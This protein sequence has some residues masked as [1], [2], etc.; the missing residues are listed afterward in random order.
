MAENYEYAN[1]LMVHAFPLLSSIFNLLFF[2]VV[3]LKRD[4]KAPFA[5][6]LI[7]IPVN[8]YGKYFYGHAVYWQSDLV[9]WSTPYVTNAVV[10]LMAFVS[11][12]VVYST[13]CLTQYL[14]GYE[15]HNS[16]WKE[17]READIEELEGK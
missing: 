8:Y 11:Y 14:H 16:I 5:M 2:K 7:Y 4:A 3:Y 15:E 10:T 12:F 17:K 6:I 13:A 9:D 1:A